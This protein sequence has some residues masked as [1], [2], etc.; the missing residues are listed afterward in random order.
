MPCFTCPPLHERTQ[1]GGCHGDER[2]PPVADAAAREDAEKEHA[3]NRAVGVAGD[4]VDEVDNAVVGQ[5]LERQDDT[6]HT[7]GHQDVDPA[8]HAGE[9]PIVA[10]F[11]A[12]QNVD[13]ERSRQSRERRTGGRIG[14]R[15]QS[16]DEQH[17]DSCGQPSVDGDQREYPVALGGNLHAVAL[18]VEVEQHAEHQEEEDDENLADGCQADIFLR[19]ARR[20]AAQVALHHVLIESRHGDQQHD[21]RRKHLPEIAVRSRVVEEKHLRIGRRGDLAGH[22]GQGH[23]QRLHDEDD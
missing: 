22:F 23:A 1:Y 18:H 12:L 14:A 17:G 5:V 8:A 16:D 7:G 10:E 3:Q 15:Y 13:G 6:R 4:F 2:H 11:R 21:A 20:G 9:T 19:V